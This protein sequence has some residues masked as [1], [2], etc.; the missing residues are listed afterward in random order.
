MRETVPEIAR[1]YKC[2]EYAVKTGIKQGRFPYIVLGGRYLLEVE[3]IDAIL[4]AEAEENRQ[5]ARAQCSNT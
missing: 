1:R 5:R 4:R 2:S 3:E